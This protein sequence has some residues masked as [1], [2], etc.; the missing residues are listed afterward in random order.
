VKPEDLEPFV[1]SIHRVLRPGGIFV[2]RDHDVTDVRMDRLVALA[3]TVF[4]CG[5]QQPWSVNE[6]E[7]RHFVSVA[8]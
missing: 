8:T 2:L 3:H 6:N 4:N 5:L 1:R 7:R